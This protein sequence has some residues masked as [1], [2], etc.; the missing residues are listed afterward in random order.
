VLGFAVPFTSLSIPV[1][2]LGQNHFAQPKLACFDFSSSN[3]LLLGHI[4]STGGVALTYMKKLNQS[5]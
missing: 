4:P 5:L 2:T 3:F 1:E